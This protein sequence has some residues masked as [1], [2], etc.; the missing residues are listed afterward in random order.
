[1]TTSHGRTRRSRPN[2]RPPVVSSQLQISSCTVC[3]KELDREHATR[4]VHV[5]SGKRRTSVTCHVCDVCAQK[6][7]QPFASKVCKRRHGGERPFACNVC[8]E[9]FVHWRQLISHADSHAPQYPF[10]CDMCVVKLRN[11]GA[12]LRHRRI[13]VGR[14]PYSCDVCGRKFRY[15]HLLVRHA[16]S[17][18]R[19][20]EI[21]TCDTCAANFKNK[22]ALNKH[23]RVHA[24][25]QVLGSQ[26][27]VILA[28][29]VTAFL[30][31]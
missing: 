25:C 3:S 5:G 13:H 16:R 19:Q 15:L 4:R 2:D 10:G 11:H 8:N 31:H 29:Y 22:T 9:A 14:K 27:S 20:P 18:T 7:S 26:V 6:F 24:D 23:E 30:R 21:F 17:H 1:M 12:L 28:T